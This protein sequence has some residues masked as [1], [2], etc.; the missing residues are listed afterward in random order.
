MA[1]NCWSTQEIISLDLP[2]KDVYKKD[3]VAEGGERDAMRIVRR[4]QEVLCNRN[5]VPLTLCESFA[6][7]LQSESDSLRQSSVTD[8]Y[9]RIMETILSKG[10]QGYLRFLLPISLNI[11]VGPEYVNSS[12]LLHRMTQMWRNNSSVA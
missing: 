2:V 11:L 1:W 10:S 7:V 3:L 4:C 6:N 9:W 8:N 5:W 12:Y